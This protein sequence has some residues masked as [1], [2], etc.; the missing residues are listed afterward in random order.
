LNLLP[1]GDRDKSDL[2]VIN[3]VNGTARVVA[4]WQSSRGLLSTTKR[5]VQR[6]HNDSWSTVVWPGGS[7]QVPWGYLPKKKLRLAVPVKMGFHQFAS[8]ASNT[9]GGE[10]DQAAV[11]GFP[12]AVF[13]ATAAHL[14]YPLRFEFVPFG[15]GSSNPSYDE[16]LQAVADKYP[17]RFEFVLFGNGS[18]NPI[19]DEMLQAVADK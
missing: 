13:R 1:N 6:G 9:T 17:L 5:L 19:Y 10:S 3:V 2:E 15:N 12:V 11:G 14:K 18:S 7:N 4:Y 8:I 16:M